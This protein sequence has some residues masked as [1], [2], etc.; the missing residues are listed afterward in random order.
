MGEMLFGPNV[1]HVGAMQGKKKDKGR[2]NS[3]GT[4]TIIKLNI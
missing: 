1:H 3:T 2:L 4:T